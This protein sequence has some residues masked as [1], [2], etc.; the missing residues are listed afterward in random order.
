MSI[1]SRIKMLVKNKGLNIGTFELSLGLSEGIIRSWRNGTE[2][3]VSSIKKI[4]KGLDTTTDF[5]LE[6]TDSPLPNYINTNISDK[7]LK[8]IL[9]LVEANISDAQS[10]ILID[11]YNE[12]QS[13]SKLNGGDVEQT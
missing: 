7:K 4:A 11:C 9:T 5:L 1:S 12:M 13:F 8:L 10:Q 3:T 2:P 6:L